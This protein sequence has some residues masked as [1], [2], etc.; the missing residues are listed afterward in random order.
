MGHEN[1]REKKDL[2]Q[3][4]SQRWGKQLAYKEIKYLFGS[5]KESAKSV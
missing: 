3:K 2:S 4:N 1:R 5:I